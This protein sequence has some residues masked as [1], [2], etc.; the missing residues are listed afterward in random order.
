MFTREVRCRAHCCTRKECDWK[1]VLLRCFCYPCPA[2]VLQIRAQMVEKDDRLNICLGVLRK[3]NDASAMDP[4]SLLLCGPCSVPL[5][6]RR[7]AMNNESTARPTKWDCNPPLWFKWNAVIADVRYSIIISAEP[8]MLSSLFT[9]R[10]LS[11]M[12]ALAQ[13]GPTLESF[14]RVSR[15][16]CSRGRRVTRATTVQCLVP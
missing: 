14:P 6:R 1:Y 15:G 2:C 16:S 10:S 4:R 13:P 8:I 3:E 7:T 11:L 9:M 12:S 5:V